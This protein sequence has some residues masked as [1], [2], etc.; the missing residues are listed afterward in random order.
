MTGSNEERA[1]Q[2]LSA[3]DTVTPFGK[4]RPEITPSDGYRVSAALC[5]MRVAR[6]AHV[7][8]RKIGFTNRAIWP[9]YGVDRPM[10]GEMY[11]TTVHDAGSGPF[12]LSGFLEPRIE[13]EIS[14]CFGRAPKPGMS[15]EDLLSCC[16]WC[17]HGFEIVQS[18]YPE[19]S[20]TTGEAIAAGAM[21]GSFVMGQRFDVT[22]VSP[23]M[24]TELTCTLSVNGDVRERGTGANVLDGP[25]SALRALVDG[26]V[27]QRQA[28]PVEAGDIITTG[29]MTDA[30]R[31]EAG[32]RWETSIDGAPLDGIAVDFV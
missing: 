28:R 23:E 19:W 9:T 3:F 26:L 12:A 6:G 14:F 31:I 15:D 11:D 21:H 29:T 24:L 18:P 32:E 25:V 13:P 4:E 2:I 1:A 16:D 22:E 17:A 27:D 10:W 7:I 30:Y 20:F 8:G 5:E